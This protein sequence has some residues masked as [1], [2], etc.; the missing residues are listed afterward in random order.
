MK[1]YKLLQLLLL[2]L[3]AFACSKDTFEEKQGNENSVLSERIASD[4]YDNS[5]FGVYKGMFTTNDGLTRGNIVINLSPNSEGFAILA[6]NSGE[7]IELKSRTPKLTLDNTVSNLSFSSV[8]YSDIDSTFEFSVESDGLNPVITNVTLDN[9]ESDIYIAKNLSRAPVSPITGTYVRTAGTG[10]FPTTGRTWNVMS[11]GAGDGQVF[12]VQIAYGGRV[13]NTGPVSAQSGCTNASGYTTCNI[14]GS[15]SI[16]GHVVS[17]NGTHKYNSGSAANEPQCAQVSGTWSAPTFGNSS[18]T[19]VSDTTCTGPAVAND[20]CANAITVNVGDSVTGSTANATTAGVPTSNCNSLSLNTAPGVWYKFTSPTPKSMIVDTQGSNYDTKLGVFSGS[21]SSLTC[22]SANDDISYPS[23]IQS[24]VSFSAAAGVTY[25][26]YVTGFQA[27]TGNYVL[28]VTEFIPP[29]NDLCANATSISVGGTA[30]GATTTA[31]TTGAPTSSCNSV[32]MNASPGVWH[33]VTPSSNM[34]L[35][36]NTVGSD[37]DTRLAIYSGSCGALSCVTANDNGPTG[38]TPQSEVVFN[39]TAGT[40]YRVYVTG[41]SAL[42]TGNYTVNVTQV[43]PP[44]NDL[45]A[46]ATSVSI[47]TPVT[48]TTLY[49]NSTGAP[50]SSC[51]SVSLNSGPGV[52]HTYTNGTGSSKLIRVSTV[53]SNFDTR[54]AILSGSCG[55]LSCV[56]ANDNGPTGVTPQSELTFTAAAGTTYRIYITAA[57]GVSGNYNLTLTEIFPPAN[58]LCANATTMTLGQ[59]LTG[60]TSS[61]TLTGAPSSTCSSN[62]LNTAPG[63]WFRY[64]SSGAQQISVD[65]EGSNF[66]TILG[67]YSGSCGTLSCIASN[68]DTLTNSQSRVVFTTNTS[69]TTYYFYVTGYSTDSGNYTINLNNT[70]SSTT[71]LGCGQTLVD[72]GGATGNYSAH[73]YDVYYIDAGAGNKAQVTFANTTNGFSLETNFDFLKI[74]DGNSV[75]STPITTATG[76]G[77]GVATTSGFTGTGSPTAG[78]ASLRG[79]TVVSTQ[80][81][82]TILLFSDYS[83]VSNGFQATVACVAAREIA[84]SPKTNILPTPL[85]GNLPVKNSGNDFTYRSKNKTVKVENVNSEYDK[86]RFEAEVLENVNVQPIIFKNDAEKIEYIRKHQ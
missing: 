42:T 51:N 10:G 61:A 54:L 15:T 82:M 78:S 77:G 79:R 53:G 55:A 23:N 11:I 56:T 70:Y 45:C 39:A 35:K 47:G 25:Y 2:C 36:I 5:Y 1:V 69:P 65:T 7:T 80:R 50:T 20:L 84:D 37:F 85:P 26:F 24:K 18:G 38:V 63:V 57:T 13:Y 76:N 16:L 75:N 66:D 48:G 19:F 9:K 71:N 44:A 21:C 40:T 49:G 58:D 33:T 64:V 73:R 3:L 27:N 22:V 46:N 74:F 86:W 43:F 8:G 31:S 67:V 81:Y 30:S 29:A 34:M 14:S 62:S 59:T 60:S 28:N 83:V 6:L 41:S 12:A 4:Q 72:H 17:W 68:D 32:S 52:W